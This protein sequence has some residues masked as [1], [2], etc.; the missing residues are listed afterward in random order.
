MKQRS[1]LLLRLSLGLLMVVWGLDK[2]VDV[3][4][5][6]A[7]SAGFYLNL[8]SVPALLQ[9]FGLL[10][11]LIGLL[12][13]AGLARRF[14]YPALLAITATT[15]LGVWKSIVDPWGWFLEGTNA[16]FHPSLIIFAASL[17]LWAFRED[18]TLAVDR[19]VRNGL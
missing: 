5:G 16:L 15:A 3:E 11:V 19:R 9:A 18:D 10:Q 7:V 12:I 1:L 4:H 6:M 13:A 2:L 8:F 17:V 14:A